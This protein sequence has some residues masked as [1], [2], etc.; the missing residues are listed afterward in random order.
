MDHVGIN[1]D[2]WDGMADQW[3]AGGEW[4]W[5]QNT[6][7]WGI[8]NL[9][10]NLVSLLPHDMRGLEAIELGCGTAYVS[11]WMAGRG[12]RVTG[13]DISGEQLRTARRLAEENDVS[14]T[15]LE[16]NAEE[17]GLPDSSFDFAVSEYGAAI[18]CDPSIWLREAWRLL[19]P[20]GRLAFLGNHPLMIIATPENGAAAD[21]R[22]H[23][24]YR[25]LNRNDWTKVEID[26]GGVDFNLSF[27]NWLRL[28][29]KI[30]FTVMDYRELYAPEN[31]EESR[32]SVRADWAKKYP[33]EQVWWLQKPAT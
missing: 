17:T 28:F 2:Y 8:W 13:I 5:S 33:S 4:L 22:L 30:G 16:G 7:V 1:R 3:V 9:P 10:D 23:R 18:W 12:A 15:L 24:S 29:R 21:F 19:R 6:P 11:A 31:V 14:M 26:P 25:S 27:E 32:F 20:G